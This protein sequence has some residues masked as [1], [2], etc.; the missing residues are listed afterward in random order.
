MKYRIGILFTLFNLATINGFSQSLNK[1][2]RGGSGSDY[3]TKVFETKDGYDAFGITHSFGAGNRDILFTKL[4]S[5]GEVVSSFAYG[6]RRGEI[7]YG[8]LQKASGNYVVL[9]QTTSYSPIAVDLEQDILV[10][11]IEPDGTLV[12]S[13]V[14]ERSDN[15]R[16]T[17]ERP[18][19]LITC[20]TGGYFVLCNEALISD[21]L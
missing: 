19:C 10:F 20:R 3:F 7:L 17:R 9:C 12:K 18:K 4:D 1:V 16:R 6:G 13:S 11:E 5:C 15:S 21:K 8:V 14:I 2:Y